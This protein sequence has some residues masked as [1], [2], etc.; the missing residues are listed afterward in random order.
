VRAEVR[1]ALAELDRRFL[2]QAIERRQHAVSRFERGEIG[3]ADLPLDVLTI[4]LRNEDRL[5]LP[6]DVVRREIAFYLQAGAHSTANSV[7]HAVHEAFTWCATRPEDA[8]RLRSDPL[9]LQRC[10]HESLRLHPASPVAWRRAQCP[11]R[12]ATGLDLSSGELVVV[13]M[14]QA[15]RD[16]SVFGADAEVFN[17]HRAVPEGVHPAGLTFG[18]G[19][20]A[21]LGKELDGGLVPK[22]ETDP[23]EHLYGT[24]TVIVRALLD[25]G[26]RPDP[27]RRPQPDASTARA[28][29][30][31][32][33]ILLAGPA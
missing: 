14:Q 10:V 21:C 27:Q 20:H 8:A 2:S 12:L 19:V 9:F 13:D 15:N 25:H 33:P 5:A 1:A 26:A 28:N 3:E 22:G 16:S 24:V 7:A 29:W 32:Y 30:G 18:T 4:L 6:A 11:V 23:A 17:P 31:S